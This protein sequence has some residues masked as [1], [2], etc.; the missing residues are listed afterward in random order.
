MVLRRFFVAPFSIRTYRAS[1]SYGA[2]IQYDNKTSE[3]IRF[4]KYHLNTLYTGK[5][6]NLHMCYDLTAYI[7]PS[8]YQHQLFN[9]GLIREEGNFTSLELGREF[10]CSLFPLLF[11]PEKPLDSI[12]NKY[13][14]SMKGY[15]VIGVQMR[16]GGTMTQFAE[17]VFLKESSIPKV[18]EVINRAI[19]RAGNQPVALFISTDSMKGQSMLEELFKGRVKIVKVTEFPIGHS[20]KMFNR[21]TDDWEGFVKRAIVDLMILKESDDLIVTNESSFGEYAADMQY[22]SYG[23]MDPAFYS[24][25]LGIH[26]SVFRAKSR[27]GVLSII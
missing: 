13:I 27:R 9:L 10:R 3:N 5:V 12:I 26:S 7:S 11:N 23:M 24:S 22:C 17:R 14:D 19:E 8:L 2:T 25:L 20:Y 15:Y 1:S 4:G 18:Q 6:V 16:F 21:E